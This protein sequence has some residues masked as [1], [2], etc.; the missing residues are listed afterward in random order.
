MESAL[1][2]EALKLRPEFTPFGLSL[3]KIKEREFNFLRKYL[4]D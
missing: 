2:M 1:L 4:V 3:S